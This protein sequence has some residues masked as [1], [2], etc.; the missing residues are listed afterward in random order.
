MAL[1]PALQQAIGDMYMNPSVS[2]EH[3]ALANAASNLAQAPRIA[4]ASTALSAQSD[5][6]VLLNATSG[7][8]VVNLPAGVNGQS[9]AIAY[10]PSNSSTW[11][12]APNGADTVAASV[13]SAMSAKTPVNIQHLNGVWYQV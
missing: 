8:N 3:V 6:R 13:T 10:H 2:A 4:L 1:S 12:M 9:F 11:T 5:Y 7:S